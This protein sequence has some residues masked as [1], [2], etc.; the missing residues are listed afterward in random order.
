M[1]TFEER[2]AYL[3]GR[4]EEHSENVNGIRDALA[5]LER[6][7]DVRFEAMDRRFEGV[8]RRLEGL[9]EKM[10]RYF[11]W[12]VGMQVTTL[13]AVMAALVGR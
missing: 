3:E 1:H 5:S 11:V 12:L 13:A 7:T 10:T 4:V 9:D 6:R 2:M 8:E